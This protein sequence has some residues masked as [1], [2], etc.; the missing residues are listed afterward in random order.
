[1]SSIAWTLTL[2]NGQI[3]HAHSDI[4]QVVPSAGVATSGVRPK[5]WQLGGGARERER[6]LAGA[7]CS[8]AKRV[9]GQ[10]WKSRLPRVVLGPCTARDPERTILDQNP[11]RS[12]ARRRCCLARQRIQ[13]Q[14]NQDLHDFNVSQKGF[15]WSPEDCYKENGSLL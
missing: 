8:G 6:S 11:T 2:S 15:S 3:V 12:Y 1:M 10:P 13:F 5:T 14:R 4:L 9:R 7:A